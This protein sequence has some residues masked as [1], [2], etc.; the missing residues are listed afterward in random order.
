LNSFGELGFTFLD[1]LS[2]AEMVVKP[3]LVLVEA[4]APVEA[5]ALVAAAAAE[6]MAV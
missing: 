1:R 6:E 5:A 3:L 4:A 2:I